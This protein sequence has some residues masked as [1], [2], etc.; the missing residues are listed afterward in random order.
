MEHLTA[1]DADRVAALRDAGAF[2]WVD[3]ERPGDA[4]LAEAGRVLRLP[5]L[6]IE[7]SQE[8][9][10]R[11]KLDDYGDRVLVVF[12]GAQGDELVE[13]HLHVSG[14]ELLTV[15]GGRIDALDRVDVAAARGEQDLVYR[16]LDALADSLVDLVGRR[17]HEAEAL[18]EAAYEHPTETERRRISSLRSELFAL[19]QTIDA[20]AEMLDRGAQVLD[21]LPG[22]DR[23]TA[24]HPFRD[25]LD[26]LVQM[27]AR[28]TYG[29]EL[30]GEALQVHLAAQGNR[31]NEVATRLTLV[32]TV[33]LPL[34]FVTGFFG[35]NFDWLVTHIESASAFFL[36]GVGGCL[37]SV[38]IPAF[39][40]WRKGLIGHRGQR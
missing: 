25:V 26:D 17:M 19:G 20:Q 33:F 8:L 21:A 4:T 2:P 34:T 31:L 40:F 24:R 38:A 27:R 5:A 37:V 14:T 39:V 7:D 15:R 36:L 9:G 13:V 12:F 11:P 23:D 29:R 3:L 22:L 16:V 35:Q 10:Q 1:F 32:A 18:E 28:V 30:L 6:A